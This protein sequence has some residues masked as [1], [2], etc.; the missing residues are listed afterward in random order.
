[1]TLGHGGEAVSW[2]QPSPL[3]LRSAHLDT[4]TGAEEDAT[5]SCIHSAG[6]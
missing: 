6:Q 5:T 1:M 2:S 3:R 4:A